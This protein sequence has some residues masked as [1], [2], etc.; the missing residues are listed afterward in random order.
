[1]NCRQQNPRI[2]FQR[3]FVFAGLI[4]SATP[5]L[6]Q[7]PTASPATEKWRPNDGLYAMPGRDFD[8]SCGEYG[9]VIVALSESHIGGSEWGCKVTRL[10]DTAPGAV[11]LDMT[12]SDYNLAESLKLPEDKDFKEV[13]YLRKIDDKSMLVR[14]SINGKLKDPAWRAAYCPET[15]Q[16]SHREQIAK[17]R[18]EAAVKA[19]WERK[20]A[21]ERKA[22]EARKAAQEPSQ[23]KGEK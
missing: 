6:A 12:C 13:M 23:P 7:Q 20:A 15:M 19:E 14:K 16:R 4:A 18:E 3:I 11:R 21:E 2:A 22:I 9:D 1:M 5:A 17:E 10:T 8:A